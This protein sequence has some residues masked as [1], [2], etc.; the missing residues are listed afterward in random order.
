MG[1]V[2]VKGNVSKPKVEQLINK[3]DNGGMHVPGATVLSD[4]AMSL[5]KNTIAG[6]KCFNIVGTLMEDNAY[7]LDDVTGIEPG[8]RYS[9]QIGNNYDFKGKVME[10]F[11]L[12]NEVRVSDE[13]ISSDVANQLFW[14]PDY[15]DLGTT[16][17]GIA[18]IST[19]EETSATA[20]GA[21]AGGK[22]TKAPGQYGT[23]IGVETEA[24][25]AGFSAGRKTKAPGACA[26]SLGDTT[27][28]SGV[29]SMSVNSNNKSTEFATFSKGFK[30]EAN[31]IYSDSSGYGTKADSPAQHV[32]GKWNI[33]DSEHKY[34]DIIGNGESDS[35][36]SNAATVD[37][38][39]NTWFAGDVE[40]KTGG[41]LSEKQD[42]DNMISNLVDVS[43][44]SKYPSVN[45][46]QNLVESTES[47]SAT[48]FSNA[49]KGKKT[50]SAIRIDDVA[51]KVDSSMKGGYSEWSSPK[52]DVSV[53]S[54]N[55]IPFPYSTTLTSVNGLTY[56]VDDDRKLTVNGTATKGT[57][58]F[59]VNSQSW[60]INKNLSGLTLT[61]SIDGDYTSLTPDNYIG[62]HWYDG[63]TWTKIN[64]LQGTNNSF[65]FTVGDGWKGFR[66][67]VGVSNGVTVNN[68]TIRPKLELGSTA[69]PYVD[70]VDIKGAVLKAQGKNLIPRGKGD[71]TTKTVNGIT[72]TR[73]S[74]GSVVANGT[75][76]VTAAYSLNFSTQKYLL[77]AGNYTLSGCPKNGSAST[78]RLDLATE[79]TT[80]FSDTGNGHSVLIPPN[81]KVSV[82]SIYVSAG[83]TVSNVVFRPQLELG[84]VATEYEPPTYAN[85]YYVE[86]NGSIAGG[87]ESTSPT[88]TLTT[89]KANTVI[90]AEYSRDINKAF[91]ELERNIA[92]QTSAE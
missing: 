74:D 68:V 84:S 42:R 31:A 55:L 29:H 37:W 78:Y 24:G 90:V 76:T 11:A 6:G 14:L 40:S 16:D 21:F 56:T 3:A 83:A 58:Y 13:P 69:T 48:S 45:G 91:A 67:F 34:A 7:I 87:V 20:P 12:R 80:V 89:D 60:F 85:S 79:D 9:V 32:Q 64:A 19:G 33:P 75:A 51:P 43:P 10:V 71:S 30:T 38:K 1:V 2:I 49:L 73:K 62:A 72:F 47:I 5:G 82:I 41:K 52:M 39:G 63:T 4:G 59:F 57:T 70:Y 92:A 50:G 46:V 61:L 77:P 53:Q 17:F 26:A 66:C 81:I 86:S 15:P 88:T 44:S 35:K 8:Y 22:K 28:A 25:W 65:T 36:R 54:K 18:A 27:E 23:S